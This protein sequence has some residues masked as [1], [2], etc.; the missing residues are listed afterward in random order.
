MNQL[1]KVYQSVLKQMDDRKD[2]AEELKTYLNLAKAS[3]S[4]KS[5]AVLTLD[6]DGNLKTTLSIIYAKGMDS[7]VKSV[8]LVIDAKKVAYKAPSL[9]KSS[10][11]IN[12]KGVEELVMGAHKLSDE[13]FNN[14]YEGMK[15]QGDQI[16][17][18]S[19]EAFLKETKPYLTEEQIKKIEALAQEAKG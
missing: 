17:K 10:D 18:E 4:D 12:R 2:S 1:L 9:P 7:L 11:I 8:D 3:L 16:S 5:K 14:M 6:K 13:D 15:A 19:I